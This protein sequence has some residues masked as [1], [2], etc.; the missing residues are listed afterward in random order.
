AG[1]CPARSPCGRHQH[2]GAG[3][4]ED[5]IV[6]LLNA[7]LEKLHAQIEEDGDN[8]RYLALTRDSAEA[9][10]LW[11]LMYLQSRVQVVPADEPQTWQQ[12]VT[13]ELAELEGRIQRLQAFLSG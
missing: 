12:R 8:D 1:L 9:A 5:E 2:R 11:R 4:N 10:M 7:L 13:A 3:M 6:A